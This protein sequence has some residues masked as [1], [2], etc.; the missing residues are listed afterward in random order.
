MRLAWVL[1]LALFA[2][3]ARGAELP[4]EF[5]KALHQVET[6][7][8][9]GPVVGD[10]GKALGPFQIHRAYWQDAGVP[11]SYEACQDYDYAVKVVTAYLNRYVPA[12]VRDRN[13]EVLARTHNGGPKGAS[14][15]KTLGYWQKVKAQLDKMR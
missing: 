2:A 8:K 7:G 6:G 12:A 11:G 1:T 9:T 14:N 15:P 3:V 13:Y 5:L 10:K 4:A